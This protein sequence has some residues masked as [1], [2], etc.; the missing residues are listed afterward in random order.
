MKACL[1]D[2]SFVIDLLNEIADAR[3]GPALVWLKRN[4]KARLWISPVTL[5]EV[6][7]GAGD[8]ETVKGWLARFAWQ[9]IH[10]MHAE[11]VA[12]RQRRSSRRMGENDVWQCAIAGRMN[13]TLVAHD[14]A[15]RML[16]ARYEDYRRPRG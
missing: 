15:F 16:G 4:P 7:E 10:R 9:G 13:A 12:T 1:L 8:L 3:E 11:A 6:L 5:A 14:A 2:S